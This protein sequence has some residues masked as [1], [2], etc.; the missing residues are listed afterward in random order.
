MWPSNPVKVRELA[1]TY[2]GP[3]WQCL[4]HFRDSSTYDFTAIWI[5]SCGHMEVTRCRLL[6][7]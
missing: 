2:E 6:G 5:R 3:C 4:R 1:K 7:G